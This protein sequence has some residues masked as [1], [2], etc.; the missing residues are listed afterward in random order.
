[1][2][3][4]L[5]GEKLAQVV[6]VKRCEKTDKVMTLMERVGTTGYHIQDCAVFTV[7]ISK[8]L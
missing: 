2:I 1:M 7:S 8:Q 5:K 6:R 4:Q 3:I